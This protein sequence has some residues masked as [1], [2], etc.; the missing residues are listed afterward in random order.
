MKNLRFPAIVLAALAV[1]FL[2]MTL[3]TAHLL[4]ERVASHFDATGRPDG[5][6]DRSSFL[7]VMGGVG[8]AFPLVFAISMPFL[9]LSKPGRSQL[10]KQSSGLTF[11]DLLRRAFWF[12]SMTLCFIA[13]VQALVVNAN[14]STPPRLQMA[15]VVIVVVAFTLGVM[16]W[17]G[18]LLYH[19]SRF[20]RLAQP[21]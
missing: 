11:A 7:L 18:S 3:S 21:A 4:P 13:A 8:L 9:I 20:H 14:A 10:L 2:V 12:G 5:W 17:A 16:F 15:M 6:T 19:F 1:G